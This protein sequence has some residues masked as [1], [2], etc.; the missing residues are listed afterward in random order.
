M[1]GYDEPSLDG[2]FNIENKCSTWFSPIELYDKENTCGDIVNSG[3]EFMYSHSIYKIKHFESR[4]DFKDN[5]ID[6][7]NRY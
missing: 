4:V 6:L 5:D 7:W 2:D 3:Y 1:T